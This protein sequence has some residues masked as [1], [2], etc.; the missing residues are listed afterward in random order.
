MMSTGKQPGTLSFLALLQEVRIRTSS[1]PLSA[2]EQRHIVHTLA[3]MLQTCAKTAARSSPGADMQEIRG[4]AHV[5]RAMEVGAAGG[6]NLLLIGPPGAGKALLARTLPSLLPQTSVPYPFRAPHFSIGAAAFGG[7]PSMPGELTLAHG[8]IL[9]LEDLDAFDLSLL[10]LLRQ[11]FE[12]HTVA[13]HQRGESML[14][15]ANFILVATLKPCPCGY[16]GDLTRECQCATEAIAQHYQRIR[17]A[18]EACFDIQVE[19]PPVGEDLLS[20]RAEESSA[21]I[22]QRVE[23]AREKQRYRYTQAPSLCVNADLGPISEVQRYCEIELPGEKLLRAALQ[24]LHLTPWQFLRIQR[25]AR[26]IAD[27]ADS[28]PIAAQH[29][30]EAIQYRSRFVR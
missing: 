22:R 21:R 30:A 19:V 3:D 8:G 10:P 2:D 24:Q 1:E 13:L 5:K 4:Q 20:K 27:L 14:F 18:V 16:Y 17:D 26:T 7:E 15:P 6:H 9:F 11:A 12:T 28:A 23:K 29:I 25:V